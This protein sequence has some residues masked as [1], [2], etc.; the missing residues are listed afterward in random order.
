MLDEIANMLHLQRTSNLLLGFCLLLPAAARAELAFAI[1]SR[2]VLAMFDTNRPATAL[3]LNVVRGL[4]PGETILGLD[5]RPANQR[6]YALSTHSRLYIID[7][8]TGQATPVHEAPF[9]PALDGVKFGFSFNPT[10]DRIRITSNTG[11]NLRV[12]PDTGA[13]VA[14]DGMLQY[15][16]STAAGG[17]MPGVVASAYTNSVAG[18]TSTTLFNFDLYRRAIVTQNPP[19][20]G[21]LNVAIQLPESDFSELTSFDISAATRK[22]YLATRESAAARSQLYEVDLEART[23]TLSGTIGVLDQVSALTVVPAGMLTPLFERLGGLDA[24]TAVVDDFLGNVVADAR[25]N[26]FF[27]G[28]LQSPGRVQAL[29]RN[30]IDQVCAGAGGPCEY[31]GRDMKRAHEGMQI[32]DVEFDALVEDLVKSLD[33]FKVPATEKAALLGI[34]APMRG[35]IVEARQMK[36]LQVR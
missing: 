25:I 11:Q 18:A 6:L 13:V 19:N 29:R 21:T 4:Q 22:G 24:I 23:V 36:Q 20:D 14:V 10:V 5:F 35:D 2:S 33:K 34:L 26:R 31:K 28:T 16:G 27:A 1:D 17:P 32:T 15:A 12:H 8:V 7:H 30:L 3:S 9:S